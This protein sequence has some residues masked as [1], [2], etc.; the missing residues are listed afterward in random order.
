MLMAEYHYRADV[1]FTRQQPLVAVSLLR[2]FA[3]RDALEQPGHTKCRATIRRAPLL[4]LDAAPITPNK[5]ISYGP[6]ATAAC[7]DDSA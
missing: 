1:K 3:P 6:P 5:C 7:A 2:H 4:A